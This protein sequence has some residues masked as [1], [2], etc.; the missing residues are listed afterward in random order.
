MK[1]NKLLLLIAVV[2]LLVIV[3]F[4]YDMASKTVKPWDKKK[5]NILK[6]YDPEFKR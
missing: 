5:N 3:F 1:K 6:K 4:T 2:F